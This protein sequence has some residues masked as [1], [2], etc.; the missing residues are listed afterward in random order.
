MLPFLSIIRLFATLTHNTVLLIFMKF[1]IRL[2]IQ[3][4]FEGN[5]NIF[6]LLQESKKVNLFK[7][8]EMMSWSLETNLSSFFIPVLFLDSVHPAGRSVWSRCS[9]SVHWALPT[10]RLAQVSGRSNDEDVPDPGVRSPISSRT[11]VHENTHYKPRLKLIVPM[12]SHYITPTLQKISQNQKI[13][14]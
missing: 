4:L 8:V 14:V 10:C 5:F 3:V 9:T 13:C 1:I 11:S 6:L 12:L 7:L 2:I